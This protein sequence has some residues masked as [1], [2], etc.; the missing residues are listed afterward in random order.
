MHWAFLCAAPEEG[1]PALFSLRRYIH[2]CAVQRQ[3]LCPSLPCPRHLTQPMTQV[4]E[5]PASIS[6][7]WL[8][9]RW[10][11]KGVP[12]HV[13]RRSQDLMCFA[14]DSV[15]PLDLSTIGPSTEEQDRKE[16]HQVLS[17]FTLRPLSALSHGLHLS[18]AL[19][20]KPSTP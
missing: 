5:D 1:D 20:D 14:L 13:S 12:P 3:G 15:S 11:E 19:K 4:R 10:L 6:G 17:V 18:C 2:V 7:K 9:D 16:T 8:W